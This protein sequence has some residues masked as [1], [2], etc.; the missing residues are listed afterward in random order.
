M[1]AYY[2]GKRM[3]AEGYV[4]IESHHAELSYNGIYTSL[5]TLVSAIENRRCI[6]EDILVTLHRMRLDKQP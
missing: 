4:S 1:I 3:R 6:I 2:K 5:Y